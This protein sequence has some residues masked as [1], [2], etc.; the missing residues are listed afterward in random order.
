[1]SLC[2]QVDN[3]TWMAPEVLLDKDYGPKADVYSLGI[4]LWELAALSVTDRA[5][6]PRLPML[7]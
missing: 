1:M 2:F 5:C 7:S 6:P 4:I 3:P